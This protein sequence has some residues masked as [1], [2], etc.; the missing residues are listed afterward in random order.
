[1][2]K[3]FLIDNK[4]VPYISGGMPSRTLDTK[5]PL[6]RDTIPPDRDTNI[7][8]STDYFYGVLAFGEGPIYRVNPNGPQDVEFNDSPLDDLINL[9]TDG[10]FNDTKVAA[11]YSVGNANSK[12]VPREFKS[13][14]GR[15][16]SPQ[17]MSGSIVL[18]AG[19][20]DG[21]PKVAI[22]QNTSQAPWDG[23]EFS[24]TIAGLHVVDDEGVSQPKSTSV[25]ITLY[26]SLGG[27]L[28][29]IEGRFENPVTITQQGIIKNAV[30]FT[31][32]ILIPPEYIDENGYRFTIEKVSNDTNSNKEVDQIAFTGWDEISLSD[33]WYTRTAYMG[34]VLR[35]Y[36]EYSGSV[37]TITSLIKGL[38][39]KVPS[40]Y[41]QPIILRSSSTGTVPEID[42]RELEVPEGPDSSG[43]N[44]YTARG[45]RLEKTGNTVLFDANP[46]IYVGTWDGTFVKK[47]TQNPAW[48]IYDLLTNKTYGLGIPEEYVD[49]F[50]FYKVAQYCD[51]VDSSTGKFM[52]IT[53]YADGTFRYK[54]RG[55]VQGIIDTLT[56]EAK[57]ALVVRQ[58]QIGLPAGTKVVERRFICNISINS[59]KQAMDIINQI[60]GLFRGVLIYSGGKI[61]LNVDLPDE[62]PV[63]IFN[64]SNILKDTLRIS[65]IKESS[66]LTGVEV[67]YMDPA[68]HYKKEV[69]RIDDP[70][71]LEELSFIENMKQLD[72]VGCDRRSQAMRFG[73][74]LLSSSKFVR[75]FA[76]FK[77]TSEAMS[78]SVGDVISVS[79]QLSS[80]SWGYGGRVAVNTN[81]TGSFLNNVLVEHF[82]APGIPSTVF[83][84][85]TYPLALRIINRQSD[86][87]NLY[88]AN[89]AYRFSTG[90]AVSGTDLI[91]FTICN[92]LDPATKTFTAVTRFD[93]NAAPVKG[94]IWSLGEVDPTQYGTSTS[95]KL[96]KIISLERDSDEVVSISASE[97]VSNVYSSADTIINYVPS[98]FPKPISPLTAPP[99]PVLNIIGEPIKQVDGKISYNLRLNTSTDNSSYPRGLQLDLAMSNPD[100]VIDLEGLN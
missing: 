19:N 72:L 37:P 36:A 67:S 44:S 38:L 32:K 12:G 61:S 78:L 5:L 74:Y 66:I 27:T 99:A 31:K 39:V 53:G 25:K 81:T 11:F 87:V 47:W 82:T 100:E 62:L 8:T 56:A 22:T 65:G 6:T 24:F 1:M 73:Q 71:T 84:A 75:R 23:L 90:N 30:K 57:L 20:I 54:P 59:Q 92:R 4:L 26:D 45:Y 34:I 18:R 83:T 50:K 28:N 76:S 97:Y 86:K 98:R 69:V 52:G 29:P 9:D 40:N 43:N 68:N 49:K 91:D 2:K 35:A 80:V 14:F 10:S 63:A 21:I 48:I 7:I 58:N 46:I 33:I 17:S 70:K 95:D 96:F 93:A 13:Y 94:D 42:W 85:N 55:Y 79:Q 64:E 77:T 15:V 41:N 3:Y 60:T 88:L 16:V 89:V 51:A